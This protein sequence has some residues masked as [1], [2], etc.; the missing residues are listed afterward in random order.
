MMNQELKQEIQESILYYQD[1]RVE[2]G[3][4]EEHYNDSDV[5]DSS[6]RE[7][8]KEDVMHNLNDLNSVRGESEDQIINFINDN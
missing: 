1:R 7:G 6:I 8:A 4:Y 3:D 2:A 5:T